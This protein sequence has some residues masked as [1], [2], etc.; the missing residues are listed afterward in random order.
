METKRFQRVLD[1][2]SLR[3]VL[4]KEFAN[5]VVEEITMVCNSHASLTTALDQCV[6][7]L[8]EIRSTSK[9]LSAVA[10]LTGDHA[11]GDAFAGLETIAYVAIDAAKKARG[12]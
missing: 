5:E 1:N 6:E 8:E 2:G 12:R 11:T 7:A 10:G 9:G 4:R 3:Q